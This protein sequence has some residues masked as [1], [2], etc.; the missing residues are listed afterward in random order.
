[1]WWPL[2][3]FRA[4]Q[5]LELKYLEIWARA[6]FSSNH[7]MSDDEYEEV[8][9]VF[10]LFK[11]KPLQMYISN[12]YLHLDLSS[13]SMLFLQEIVCVELSG[14]IDCK[15]SNFVG[16]KCKFIVSLPFL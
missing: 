16:K 12:Y 2:L 10:A 13:I 5:R 14:L 1:M 6:S 3:W 9:Y 7:E 15:W 4:K 8:L 11:D